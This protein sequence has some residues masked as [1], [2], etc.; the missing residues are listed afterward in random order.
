MGIIVD[1]VIQVMVI[2]A[3][4]AIFLQTYRKAATGRQSLPTRRSAAPVP[5]A[6]AQSNVPIVRRPEAADAPVR[7]TDPSLPPSYD[8]CAA[9]IAAMT[10]PGLCTPPPEPSLPTASP[11]SLRKRNDTW[12]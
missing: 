5:A 6:P 10:G 11:T 2:V 7:S 3:I 1:G 9:M 12:P 8:A 4:A